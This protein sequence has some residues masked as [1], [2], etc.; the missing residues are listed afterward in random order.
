MEILSIFVTIIVLRGLEEVLWRVS[1]IVGKPQDGGVI[2][3]PVAVTSEALLITL[4]GDFSLSFQGRRPVF[5]SPLRLYRRRLRLLN[6]DVSCPRL[7]AR[8]RIGGLVGRRNRERR[9]WR[10]RSM[11]S[12]V[13]SPDVR[14]GESRPSIRISSDMLAVEGES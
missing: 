9:Y 8:R 13:R 11:H 14:G 7:R 3:S 12:P 1:A 4:L 6:E 2:F 10:R 5:V